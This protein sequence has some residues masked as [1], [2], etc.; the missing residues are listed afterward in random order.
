MKTAKPI[1]FVG[2]PV[3]VVWGVVEAYRFHPVLAVLMV[4]MV[5]VVGAFTAMTVVV[6]RRERL[7]ERASEGRSA[8]PVNAAGDRGH[9]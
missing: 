3:G 9:A 4:L 8:A 6:A 7:A 5:S 1:L 2:T